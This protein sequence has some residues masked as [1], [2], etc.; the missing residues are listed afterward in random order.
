MFTLSLAFGSVAAHGL[1]TVLGLTLTAFA[2]FLLLRRITGHFGVALVIGLAFGFWPYTYVIGWTWP[3]YVH[4][5]VFVLLFWRM[6]VLSEQPTIRNGLL[7]GGAT[8][9]AM[10]WIQYNLLIAGVLYATMAAVALVRAWS[11]RTL[12]SQIRAQVA[13][14]A[15]VVVSGGCGPGRG[16]RLGL[17]GLPARAADDA[18]SASA[19]PLMY[20]LPGPNHPLFGDSI[21]DWLDAQVRR[22]CL[23]PEEH[24][25]VRDDLPGNP[26]DAA[27]HRGA[28]ARL[29]GSCASERARPATPTSSGW[30]RSLSSRVSWR[31]CSPPRPASRCSG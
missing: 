23:R 21:G 12:R 24:R 26:A 20:L 25:L 14:A 11:S 7:A 10:T 3:P 17:Q 4:L 18:V 31:S 9:V 2:M 8:A 27:R 22:P 19:R 13:A 16:G 6:L 1:T 30:L 5:W 29:R 15:V 28:P